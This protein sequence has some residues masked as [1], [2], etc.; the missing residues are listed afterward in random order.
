MSLEVVIIIIGALFSAMMIAVSYFINRQIQPKQ[1]WLL[2]FAEMWE[3]FSFYGM[4]ALLILFLTKVMLYDDTKANL[5]YGVYNALAYTFP[6]L[7]GWIADR[8]LGYRKSI[9]WGGVLMTIGHLVLA[10]PVQSTFFLGL[11]FLISGN[12]F[13]KPNISSLLGK[14]YSQNDKRKDSGYSIFYMGINIGAFLGGALC[15]YLGQEISWHLGFGV[16]GIFMLLGLLIFI[17]F[18]HTLGSEGYA[19]DKAVLQQKNAGI[20]TEWWFYIGAALAV[21][22]FMWLLQQYE[23]KLYLSIAFGIA[24]VVYLVYISYQFDMV[25]RKKLWAAIV[26]ILVS[27]LFWGFFEQGGGSLNLMALRNVDMRIGSH[28]LSSAMINNAINPFYIVLLS[29][30]MA[31]FWQLLAKRNRE[32]SIPL[33]F[34]LSFLL[35]G[36][37]Y[38]VFYLGGIKGAASG[39]MPLIYFVGAYLFITMG[40]L[41]L[42]PIG[43]SMVTKLSPTKMFGLVMGM[44]FLATAFGQDLAG[45]IGTKM[46]IPKGHIDGTPFS[47]VESLPIYMQG[48]K[49][50]FICSF[51][52][53]ILLILLSPMIKKWMHDAA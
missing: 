8:Y 10:I 20:T 12:S 39:Y 42:S 44:W 37:G 45:Y 26:L 48:C 35:V 29:P 53:G 31:F 7:G 34:A 40:E 50:I 46:A 11:G 18:Q 52:T 30:L 43:L 19:P 21:L 4:R 9:V 32:P 23:L 38:A 28:S 5:Q 16:A 24:S 36:I 22:L 2:F 13:F 51:I 6:L 47:A 25:V 49:T 17:L 33:K 41:F 14:F 27:V 3:R 15:G 1:L